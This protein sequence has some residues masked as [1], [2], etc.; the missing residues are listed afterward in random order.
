MDN[1]LQAAFVGMFA[2]IVCGIAPLIAALRK[3]RETL[4]VTSILI[5]ALC[6]ALG[7]VILATPVSLMLFALALT[8]G[9][10]NE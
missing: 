1:I 8:G 10:K 9:T 6:G 4:A 5:C 7:G 2:G 3:N